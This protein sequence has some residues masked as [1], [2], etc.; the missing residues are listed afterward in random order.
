MNYNESLDYIFE[1]YMQKKQAIKGKRYQEYKNT[2]IIR[3]L[4]NE[5]QLQ[6]NRSK[7]IKITGSK[8]K[9]TT[10]RT[11][12]HMLETQTQKQ[13]ALFTSPEE[14]DHTDR[15]SING[16]NITKEEFSEIVSELKAILEKAKTSF[17]LLDYFSPYG[18]FLVVAMTW[19]KKKSADLYVI[20]CGRGARYDDSSS[21]DAEIGVITSIFKEH[22][23]YFGPDE[24][25]VFQDKIAISESSHLLIVPHRLKG[26]DLPK[27]TKFVDDTE[28][29]DI[30]IPH[31]YK[32]SFQL[33]KEVTR[34]LLGSEYSFSENDFRS[35]SFGSLT[36]EHRSIVYDS[37]IDISGIDENWVNRHRD[38]FFFISIPD[39][40][41]FDQFL[42]RVS[43]LRL[44]FK[45][46]ALS[47]TRGYLDYDK[48]L[49][50]PY[51][52][53]SLEYGA[54]QKLAFY[55]Q[56]SSSEKIVFWGT[57]SFIRFIKAGLA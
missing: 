51:P 22:L 42:S 36:N 13:V 21:I 24:Q 26:Y 1:T 48:T 7:V 8:G 45:L 34:T 14:I 2:S 10:A 25:H 49:E 19:F 30:N 16:E 29:I 43:E 47:G 31:V 28:D 44:Q 3:N 18:L 27:H 20:E 55:R 33:A 4:I 46:I 11:I 54:P 50:S 35:T 23:D 15:I 40:K 17:S 53:I 56:H 52:S 32:R 57:Q 5:L 37:L 6:P 12:A 39:D 38:Y 41:D 9:G